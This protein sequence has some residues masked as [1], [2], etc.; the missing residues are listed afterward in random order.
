[1]SKHMDPSVWGPVFW[2]VLHT[3]SFVAQRSDFSR[4]I[5][6]MQTLLPCKHCRSSFVDLCRRFPLRPEVDAAQW[7]WKVHDDVNM[8]LMRQALPFSKLKARQEAFR[9]QVTDDDAW[10]FVFVS[11]LAA[12]EREGL[13]VVDAAGEVGSVLS[14]CLAPLATRSCFHFPPLQDP[15]V[16]GR[17]IEEVFLSYAAAKQAADRADAIPPEAVE[18]L[19]KRYSAP[20]P[21]PPPPRP[22][23]PVARRPRRNPVAPHEIAAGARRGGGAFTFGGSSSFRA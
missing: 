3:A 9:A 12:K 2:K 19:R 22:P 16:C 6:L 1:M 8:K 5:L 18:E 4:L 20:S 23:P 15:A 21:P 11:V 7:L 17:T 14:R 13:A 10:S